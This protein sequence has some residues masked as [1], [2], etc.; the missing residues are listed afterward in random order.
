MKTSS[1]APAAAERER[2]MKAA[3]KLKTDELR[4]Q[5][6]AE[7]DQ[8]AAPVV[9]VAPAVERMEGEVAR[10][11]WKAE[12]TDMGAL[13]QAAANGTEAGLGWASRYGI[14]DRP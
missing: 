9:Q 11:T 8:I 13:V 7:A 6:M 3:A 4:E 1:E 14:G 2:A 5:R 12:L 10:V